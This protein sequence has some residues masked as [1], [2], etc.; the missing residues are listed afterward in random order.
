MF[1]YTDIFIIKLLAE[2]GKTE[3]LIADYSFS[4][5]VANIL[6]LI[7]ITLIQVDYEKIKKHAKYVR[8]LNKRIFYLL[9][10]STFGLAIGFKILTGI[11]N[12]TIYA[13]TYTLFLVILGT[14]IFQSLTV[15]FGVNLI[16]HKQFN[17][18]LLV[19]LLMLSLNMILSYVL[20]FKFGLFGVAFA[21]GL[22]L[23]IRLLVLIKLNREYIK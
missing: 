8:V 12:Y 3:I 18:N 20:F 11:G 23:L 2:S 1:L 15:V 9:M 19:N 22:S 16:I 6:M 21:S 17:K 4:L 7:P 14:K 10:I 13:N 5:N